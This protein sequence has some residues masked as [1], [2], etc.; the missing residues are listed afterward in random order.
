MA[1]L[2]PLRSLREPLLQ[3]VARGA[4]G[5]SG[6][7]RHP[8]APAAIRVERTKSRRGGESAE[9]TAITFWFV[10]GPQLPAP[11]LSRTATG[12]RS[13]AGL[14]MTLVGAAALAVASSLA[15][16]REE[17]RRLTA[18]RPVRTLRS[19]P[20]RRRPAA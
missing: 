4:A 13:A 14:G 20:A 8:L 6:A 16:Q 7:D 17:Q 15:A 11:G 1:S 12:W 9:Q 18:P 2:D 19:A 5:L 10:E 3:A